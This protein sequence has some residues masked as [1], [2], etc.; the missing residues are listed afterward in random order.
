MLGVAAAAIVTQFSTFVYCIRVYINSL[1]DDG[2]TTTVSSA[3]PSRLESV[4]TVSARQAF[5]RI[6]RVFALQWRGML[7][8]ILIIVD[9]AFFAI[10]FIKFDRST[11]VTKM[12]LTKAE[13]WLACL[14]LSRGD[15][16]QCLW[17]AKK[18]TV[19]EATAITVLILLSVSPL[20]K[21]K[22]KN[23]G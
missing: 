21:E 16:H 14:V 23:I 6:K 9:V 11:G 8:V 4:R 15:K 3:L 7:I 10:V 2:A 20:V 22:E 5:K 17:L 19:G 1:L 18:L 13:K 12:N